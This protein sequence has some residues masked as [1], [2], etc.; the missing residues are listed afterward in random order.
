MWLWDSPPEHVEH[1]S[2]H[3]PERTAALAGA[4]RELAER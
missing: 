3:G 1:P 2:A 4:L